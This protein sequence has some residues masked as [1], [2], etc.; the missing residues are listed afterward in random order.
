M[1]SANLYKKRR[2]I[3]VYRKG[4]RNK[5]LLKL[6]EHLP[7]PP[8]SIKVIILLVISSPLILCF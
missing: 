5:R 3:M 1:A 6:N 4:E 7:I 2:S 8:F